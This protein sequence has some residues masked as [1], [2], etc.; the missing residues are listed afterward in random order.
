MFLWVFIVVTVIVIRLM[1]S[2]M[3]NLEIANRIC[4]PLLSQLEVRA[5]N[6]ALLAVLI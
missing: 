3:S 4:P 6:V 5:R 1:M 2:S